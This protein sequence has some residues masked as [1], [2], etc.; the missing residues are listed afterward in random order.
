MAVVSVWI[1]LLITLTTVSRA[2]EP[3]D[4][5]LKNGSFEIAAA[6][7]DRPADW[8]WQ[9]GIIWQSDGVNHWVVEEAREVASLSIGQLVPLEERYWKL[10][11]SCQVKVTDVRQG[12]ESWHDAR[13]A[14]QFQDA[15]G[16]MVGAWPNVLHF[17]GTMT[18]WEEHQRDYIIPEGA[19][20]LSLSCSLFTTTGKV[21]W[22]DVSVMLLKL[23]PVPEDAT[24]PEGVVA[25]WDL[26]SAYREET[27]TR[28]RVCI[29]GLWRFHPVKLAETTLPA[30][31]T[32]WGYLKVPGTWNPSVSRQRAFGPD[33]WEA[34]LDLNAIDAAWYQREI[35]VPQEWAGRRV[36]INLDNPKQWAKVLIDRKEVGRI[37]W[38]GGRLDITGF[39]TPGQTHELSVYTLALPLEENDI[40]VMG[41][42][43]IEQVRTSVHFKGLCGDCYLESE[44][45]GAAIIDVF[46]K[47]SVRNKE[48]R[49]AC[50]LRGLE[51][52]RRYLLAAV[53]MDDEEV[54]KEFS[55]GWFNGA[56]R[57]EFAG[58]WEDPKLWDIDQPNLYTLLL[59]LRDEDGKLIDQITPIRF[60]FREF[61]IEGKDFRLNGTPVHLRCLDYFNAERDFGLASYA[62]AK[63]TF[64]QARKMGFNYVIHS[65]YDF[66]AQSFAY[67]DDTVRAGDE[68]GFPM[69]FS[70]RHVKRIWDDFENPEKRQLW[71]RVVEYEVRKYRNHPSIFMWA[72]NHNFTGWADDQNPAQLHGK[73]EPRPEDD[74][75]LYQRRHAATLAEQFVMSLDGT[76][77][78]YHHQS[79]PFNQMTTLNCYLCWTP[80][81]ER[82]E[83]ISRWRAEGIKPLFFVEFGL[84]HQASWGGHREGPFIWT[85]NVNSEPL[86]AEFGAIY[87]GD[88]AY[89]LTDYDVAHYETVERVY[90][91]GEPFHISSVLGAYWDRRWE[92]NFLE[93]KSLFTEHTWPAFRTYGV[94]AILP[95]DQSDLFKPIAGAPPETVL[96]ETDWEHLQRPGLAPDFI[97]WNTDWLTCPKP[98]GSIAPT[99]LGKTFARVNRETLAYIAGPPERFTAQDHVFTSG[100][101]VT[102]QVVFLNDLRREVT[103]HYSCTVEEEVGEGAPMKPIREFVGEGQVPAGGKFVAP[104][105]F[106]APSV[107]KNTSAYIRLVGKVDGHTDETLQDTFKLTLVP[108]HPTLKLPART[109]IACFDP[110]GLTQQAL[111]ALGVSVVTVGR[112]VCPVGCSVFIIGREAI[113]LQ[114]PP[115]DLPAIM[116]SGATVLIFEQTE[117]VLQ[118]LWG[119]R[120][121]SP[122]TRRVFVRQPGHPVCEGLTDD[123]LRDWRGSSTLL[124][125]YP[126]RTGY[127]GD[128]PRQEWCGFNNSRTWQWGNYGTVASV[129]VEKPQ[130]G[131][132]S[133][134]LDCEFDLQYTPLFEWL[135]PEGRT[136]FCQL[137]LSGREGTDPIADRVLA[138]LLKYAVSTP[139]PKLSRARYIGGEKMH[140]VLVDLGLRE[141]EGRALIVGPEADPAAAR[142]ALEGAETVVCLGLEGEELSR[143]LPFPITTAD[144]LV[145]HTLIGRPREGTLVGLGNADF[146]WRGRIPV[147]AITQAPEQFAVLDTGVLAEGIVGAKRYV[148][149]QFS[150]LDF[151][152]AG[153]PYLKLSY[154]RAAIALARILTN[155][156]IAL[157]GPAAWR[158]KELPPQDLDLAGEWRLIADPE[159]KLTAEALS[160]TNFDDSQWP[161]VI[162]PG[163]WESQVPELA[164]Y[165]GLVWYRKE[166]TLPQAFDTPVNLSLGAIDDEDWTYL[167]GQ[168]IGHIGQDT[169]PDNYWSAQREYT[170]PPAALRQG[171]N[172]L[173]VKVNDLRQIGGIVKGPVGF[174]HPGPWLHSY[175][176]DTPTDLDDPYRYYRW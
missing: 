89:E 176:L 127:Y 134:L 14:M 12:V 61:W 19:R 124:E 102:K 105:R 103:F 132:Y 162:V 16:N 169:H 80:L 15:N 88:R 36:F 49:L 22:D 9:S 100:D 140:E 112:P 121:T 130:R 167:N 43:Q 4:E 143:I 101:T 93:I 85:N 41:P 29:N 35:T 91:R 95:W 137:D 122:G 114:G 28:G 141:S 145:T 6:S 62:M 31:G 79:G 81:Q 163:T 159:E 106:V 115:V 42:D 120:T 131:N 1:G 20:Q 125:A 40:R 170:V 7:G 57:F 149:V 158:L 78:C 142:A 17:T 147:P 63:H 70:I 86:V 37:E 153:K 5:L 150:P 30:A 55:S 109:R 18:D 164:D 66:E 129:V 156:G 8:L 54:A 67:I 144:R 119:F 171:V 107:K 108:P 71:N 51:E 146:H 104:I 11:V 34:T 74:Q 39:V 33:I 157:D 97:A 45:L 99:S 152:Y 117:E 69:S 2:A 87:N 60:G 53:V 135:T 83:W 116:Q 13:I 76:R 56:D 155:C 118:R 48:L 52:E 24:L 148:L 98:A 113:G 92:H 68:V 82:M 77:P 161:R 32:G 151:D 173:V 128:Y 138:N 23:D 84:P 25:R 90:A 27:P 139:K 96:L 46:I 154:R 65:H 172:V 73:F 26:E 58:Q 50:E 75:N 38:P 47:P 3:G 111:K 168:A 10:R 44:P 94:S 123:L 64:S 110:K 126:E 174:F 175:Y 21:E 165:T 136:I 160:Q 166:F 59:M 72:M 133:F